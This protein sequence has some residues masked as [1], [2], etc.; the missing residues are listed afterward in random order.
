[1]T[2]EGAPKLLDFG[3]AKLLDAG[4]AAAALALTRMND[5]LL[6]PEYASPEQI[7]GRP[8][9]TASDVYALASSC[10]SC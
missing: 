9:T 1:M 7:L 2:A 10:T 8:V 3:I 4:D 6:T 5:R